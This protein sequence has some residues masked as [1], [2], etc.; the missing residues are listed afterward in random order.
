MNVN[1]FHMN[2]FWICDM[3][4]QN[5]KTCIQRNVNREVFHQNAQERCLSRVQKKF[6]VVQIQYTHQL[7]LWLIIFIFF[8]HHTLSWVSLW[9]TDTKIPCT[10]LVP[11]LPLPISVPYLAI[12]LCLSLANLRFFHETLCSCIILIQDIFLPS[13]REHMGVE[14]RLSSNYLS[15]RMYSKGLCCMAILEEL[16]L[17]L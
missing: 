5:D 8:K 3:L 13:S 14:A 2:V 7:F 4:F 11:A 10:F 16:P 6:P 15:S 1:F 9:Y 17:F 12:D